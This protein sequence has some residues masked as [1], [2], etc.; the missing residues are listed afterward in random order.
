MK[1]EKIDDK[2]RVWTIA[3]CTERRIRE[4]L[5]QGIF[6][7]LDPVA[8]ALVVAAGKQH[9]AETRDW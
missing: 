1:H 8:D 7:T 5:D 3:H 9:V 6:A 2:A 4:E